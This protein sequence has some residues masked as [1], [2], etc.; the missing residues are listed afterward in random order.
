MSTEYIV[1]NASCISTVDLAAWLLLVWCDRSADQLF[2]MDLYHVTFTAAFYSHLCSQASPY[3]AALELA[4][5]QLDRL[6][7]Y[8]WTYW[9]LAVERMP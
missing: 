6:V 3:F 2:T 9:Q 7:P 1:C 8:G 5:Q 4:S